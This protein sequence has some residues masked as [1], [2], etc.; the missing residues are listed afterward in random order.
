MNN[1]DATKCTLLKYPVEWRQT[2]IGQKNF[3]PIYHL[4]KFPSFVNG[5]QKIGQGAL[6]TEDISNI[7]YVCLHSDS[8][9][10][11]G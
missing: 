1:F 7:D 9:K 10:T 4:A 8:K 11:Q 5:L 2:R 3:T 6:H